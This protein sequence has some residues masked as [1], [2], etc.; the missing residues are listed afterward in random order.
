MLS[1]T[2]VVTA[3]L[4]GT[5]GCL[6]IWVAAPYNNFFLNNSYISDTYFPVS[7]VIFMLVLILLINPVLHLVHR[8]SRLTGR[9][10][11]LVFV[12]LMAGACVPS[13][14]LL[15]MLPWS[16]SR[17]T[18]QINNNPR[19]EEAFDQAQVPHVL[20]P[21]EIGYEKPTPISDQFLDELEPGNAVPWDAWLPLLLV[22][23]SFLLACWL[24]MVGVGL[25]LF[26]EWK[27]KERLQFPLLDV[28]RAVLPDADGKHLL[29]AI[30]RRRTFWLGAGI[31]MFL[32]A[33]AGLHHHAH[34]LVPQIPLG[35]R[36]SHV[37]SEEPWRYL[38]HS[39]KNVNHIYFILV[40]MAFFMPNRVGFS[41]WFTTI[42]YG[43]Y[44]MMQKAYFPPFRGGMVNDHRNGAMIAVVVMVLF[45]SRRHWLRVGKLMFSRAMADSDRLLKMSGWM[46]AVG[47]LGMFIWLRWANVPS[48]LAAVFVMLGFMVSVLIARIVAETG[49][50]FVRITGLNPIY[51]LAMLP[52]GWLSGAAI[53]MAGFISMIFPLGSRVSAAVMASHAIGLDTKASAKYQLR[54]GYLMIGVLLVGLVV[55]GAVHLHM[56]YTQATTMDGT[57][58]SLNDWGTR[59]MMGPQRDLVRFHSDY[60]P[61]PSD[62]LGNLAVGIVIAGALQ[63]GC[64]LSAS[65][66]IHPIGMLLV[67]HYYGQM[68]WASVLIGW[69]LKITIINYGGATAFRRAQ[70]LFMGIIMGEIFSAIIWTL[71]PVGLLLSGEDPSRVGHIPLLPT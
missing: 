42:V 50:P 13:Q 49:M 7:A 35:W 64:M 56:G 44:E 38:P 19:L 55:G 8:P 25:V 11:I 57:F 51:F 39:I 52:A 26:P 63:I 58:A 65:W 71:V 22:W 18:Q 20:F 14:G 1:I 69:A 68:A 60:W 12:M 34:G 62:R 61:M 17:T 30:F 46:I 48:I 45:L 15:R 70:P 53:Y 6:F 59:R 32:Y 28:Y 40:G 10:L 16:L 21:D 3:L 2:R 33:L 67:G 37:L 9:Q 5:I 41:I 23:G 4:I 31:V 43:F 29:P 66:P 47:C 54:I 24:M 36:L 27:N